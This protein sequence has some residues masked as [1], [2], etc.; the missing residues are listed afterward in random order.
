[1]R[2]YLKELKPTE[3]EDII[4]MNALYRP[5]PMELIPSYIKRKHKIEEVKYLHPK[6]EPIL[7]I[8]TA[9]AF[10]RNK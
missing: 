1:M 8:L 10:I 5:G 9:S 7:K 2:R 3:F 6:L 4:A